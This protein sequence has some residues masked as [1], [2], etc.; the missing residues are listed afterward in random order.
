MHTSIILQVALNNFFDDEKLEFSIV[1]FAIALERLMKQHLFETDEILVLDKN[2][3]IEHLARFRKL[4]TKISK[5]TYK[6][7]I[8]SLKE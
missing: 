8:E 3:S 7:K 2:N 5:E 1:L 4:Q 6:Q